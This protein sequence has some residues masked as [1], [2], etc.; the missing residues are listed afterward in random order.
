MDRLISWSLAHRALVLLLAG[1]LLV[2]GLYVARNAPVD[3]F[4]DLTAPT[5]AVLTEAPGFATEE[6][7]RLVTFPVESVLTG[8]GGVRRVRSFSTAGISIVYVDFDWGVDVLRAR[9]T[10]SEKLS[11]ASQALPETVRAPALGPITSIMGEVSFAGL[12][13]ASDDPFA[14]RDFAD[15]IL[16]RRLLAVPGVA[17]VSVLG[18]AAREF[19]VALDPARLAAHGAGVGAVAEALRRANQTVSAG[20]ASAGGTE[21]VITSGGRLR[22]AADVAETVV[23][24]R[25]DAPVRVSDLG[26]VTEAA[27]PVRGAGSVMGESGI[28]I[29]IQK[30]PEV[31]TLELTKRLDAALDDLQRELPPGATLHRDLLRQA[32]FIEVTLRNL[33]HALRDGA[34]LV[35][36]IVGLFLLNLRAT[37]ITITALPLSLLAALLVLDALGHTL[38]AMTIGGMAIAV[39]ALVDDAVIDVENVFRRLCENARLPEARRVRAIDVVRDASVEIR[40]SIVFATLIIILVFLPSFFLDGVEGRLLLPLGLTY[41]IA[42]AASLI[43]ALT[44][45]PVLC[46]LLLP[47]SRAVRSGHEPAPV[48]AVRGGYERMLAPVL[49]RPLLILAPSLL[50]LGAAGW[51][52]SRLGSS[53]LP[54]FQ[55]GAL[56][57]TAVTLPGV[58]MEQ[59]DR[60]VRVAERLLLAQPEVRS[61]A[62]RTGRAE[63]DE[64]A[65][66]VEFSELDVRLAPG[67]G[68]KEELLA[69]LRAELTM[70][71]GLQFS[72]G[73]PISHR[74]DHM[75]SGT[76]AAIAVKV[77][78]R[79]LAELRRIAESVRAAM[80]AVPGAVDAAVETQVEV[81][82]LRLTPD[83]GAL[84][85]LG[86]PA[87]EF[88]AVAEALYQGHLATEVI[89]GTARYGVMLRLGSEEPD[90]AAL[91]QVPVAAAGALHPLG[92]LA[93]IR[94]TSAPNKIGHENGERRI[95]VSCNVAGRDLGA[96]AHEVRQA[97]DPV[98]AAAPGHRVEYAGQF[99][100]AASARTRLLLLGAL[101][102]LGI[103]FLLHAAFDNTRDALLVMTNLPLALIGGVAGVWWSGGVLSIGAL[104]GFIAVFGIAARN[105]IMLVSHVRHLQL[106]E[107]VSDFHEAV[108]RGCRERVVPILMTALAAGLALVPLA[109]AGGKPGSEIQTPMAQVIL[110]GLL[111]STALNLLVV[112]ALYLR[113]G[114]PAVPTVR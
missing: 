73:Q 3:V 79:D 90:P 18:G 33:L 65:E 59:S 24:D 47:Q 89:A 22:G 10:V 42:L 2:W 114:R 94:R 105:G 96:V 12:T 87:D 7:E 14:L 85:A 29:G 83:R 70:V 11:L 103:G 41:V 17:Q 102:V 110:G 98:V 27:R 99:E 109:L 38:N 4:P 61:I 100:S 45:T 71:P 95:V 113:F 97:V 77:F 50:L 49:R 25:P 80:Q 44:V 64:H 16:R 23:I 31:N 39:G 92:S 82:A 51:S 28:V 104:V 35:V 108:T 43:V 55:E 1:F 63:L 112:P 84:A 52:A 8:A 60:L 69:R 91:A 74:I 88:A 37:A 48:R 5:V 40:G 30:Q 15:R 20:F 72:F 75:L 67:I 34:I 53:F 19:R 9:Q 106:R 86:V 54:E 46:L 107:G 58:S 26:E 111:S 62:R 66:G 21:Y 32:D 101:V 36:A 13:G 78:G 68:D 76:R 81:P 57:I 6:V 56:T 93:E